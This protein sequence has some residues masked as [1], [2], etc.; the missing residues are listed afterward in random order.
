[1]APGASEQ[2]IPSVGERW[3]DR[4]APW[5][6]YVAKPIGGSED[7]AVGKAVVRASGDKRLIWATKP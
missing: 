5:P 4:G 6:V 3:R 1:M 2:V 7:A